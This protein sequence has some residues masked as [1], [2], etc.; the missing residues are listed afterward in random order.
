[1]SFFE[2]IIVK[3]IHGFKKNDACKPQQR[4]IRLLK[5][6]LFKKQD[7]TRRNVLLYYLYNT[8]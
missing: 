1:M 4:K 8:N 7:L 5:A 2:S 6:A 3:N